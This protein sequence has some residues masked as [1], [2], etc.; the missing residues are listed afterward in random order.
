MTNKDEDWPKWN[1]CPLS[2]WFLRKSVKVMVYAQMFSVESNYEIRMRTPR[3]LSFVSGRCLLIAQTVLI[4]HLCRWQDG[5]PICWVVIQSS[6]FLAVSV[7]LVEDRFRECLSKVQAP[8]IF[9]KQTPL[10]LIYWL[11]L[12]LTNVGLVLWMLKLALMA[13]PQL[14]FA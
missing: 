12:T 5:I 11:Y 7:W 10:P 4:L 6:Q 14:G 1:V 3:H 13:L 8:K 9:P 2:Y